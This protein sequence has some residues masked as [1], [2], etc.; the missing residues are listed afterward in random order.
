MNFSKDKIILLSSHIVSDI[1]STCENLA[2]LNY[3]NAIYDGRKK[4]L[5]DECNGKI[6]EFV[7]SI[8][9]SV[10]LEE[11]F[12]VSS[13]NICH[14]EAVLRVVSEE[15]PV[16]SAVNVSPT[17]NDAYIYKIDEDDKKFEES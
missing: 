14:N 16:D 2:I 13:K 7:T 11:K 9:E 10:A 15:K 3:G 5:L 17:L 8:E 1:E 4:A 12:S 6:W